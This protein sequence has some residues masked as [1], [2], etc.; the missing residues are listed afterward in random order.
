MSISAWNVGW[1]HY[2]NLTIN[3]NNKD[4][5]ST[6]YDGRQ[7]IVQS[8]TVAGSA[9][10]ALIA[11]PVAGIGRWKCIIIC[12]TIAIIGGAFT[13]FYHNFYLLCIGKFL[14]GMACGGFSF[15]C[16]KYIG[17]C[18]PKEVSGPAGSMF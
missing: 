18:S 7:S 14:Y 5:G 1:P 4:I 15:Y 8:L 9:V 10:G 13:L 6:E 3:E 12:N 16:P 17:E 2:K 11:G